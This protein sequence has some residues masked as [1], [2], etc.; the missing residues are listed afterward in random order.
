SNAVKFTRD[1]AIALSVVARG[2]DVIFP[3]KDTGVGLSRAEIDKIGARFTAASGEGV[4]GAKGAGLGLALAF[5]LAELHGG[6]IALK[7]APGEGLAAIVRLPIKAPAR[8]GRPNPFRESAERPA[9]LTQLDRIE[10]YKREREASA[11]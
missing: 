10:A 2:G 6:A 1:G 3:V 11:A 4:R 9:V 7:S 8:L 5:A